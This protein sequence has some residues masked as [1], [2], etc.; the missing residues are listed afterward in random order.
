MAKK[1]LKKCE[2][3]RCRNKTDGRKHCA[4]CRS[5][6]SRKENAMRYA[7]QA[8]KDNAKRRGKIHTITFE[9]FKEFCHETDYMAGKGR[10]K[11]S[12]S[13]DCIINELGYVPGNLRKLTVS[14]NAKKGTKI[15]NYDYQTKTATVSTV[16]PRSEEWFDE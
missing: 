8:N 5:R 10:T 12:F 13:I 1:K 11:E 3:P 7:Y 6:K 9:D 14:E 16:A 4:T 15:L 2:T